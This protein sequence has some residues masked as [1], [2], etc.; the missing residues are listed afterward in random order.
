MLLLRRH[1]MV[2]FSVLNNF[3]S[4]PGC[5]QV[6]SSFKSSLINSFSDSKSPDQ[7]KHKFSRNAPASISLG[8]FI[9]NGGDGAGNNAAPQQGPPLFRSG[10]TLNMLYTICAYSVLCLFVLYPEHAR[11]VFRKHVAVVS[12]PSARLL[13]VPET[14]FLSGSDKLSL[15]Q[16]F[17]LQVGLYELLHLARDVRSHL[18][19]VFGKSFHGV[20]H[21]VPRHARHELRGSFRLH[22]VLSAFIPP[23]WEIMHASS[24]EAK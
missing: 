15:P 13:L 21:E 12:D 4:P 22:E 20:I 7:A 19:R 18:S 1:E 9:N 8:F 14:Y 11:V 10:A 17:R 24:R 16:G 2:T 23:T 6:P 5:D 3:L